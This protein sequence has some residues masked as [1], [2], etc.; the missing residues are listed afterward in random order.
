MDDHHFAIKTQGLQ[1]IFGDVVAV[2]GIDLDVQRG[3]ITGLLGGNGAGKSTT[4]AML[5]G[6]LEPTSGAIEILGHDLWRDRAK[7]APL[8]NF[9]SPYVDL[10]NRLTVRQNLTVYGHLY[11]VAHLH[12]R[13]VHLAERLQI[14]A[15][16]DRRHGTLSSG[17][18]TR[19]SLAKSLLNEPR[20]LLL[21]EPTASLDPDT[22]DWVRSLLID[23][24]QETG[25]TIFMAS[26][27]MVEVERMCDEVVM[28]GQGKIVDHGSPQK[29]LESYGRPNLEEVFLDIARNRTAAS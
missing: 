26:H 19:A 23:Y 11:G 17:Q 20:L 13:I 24:R 22:A 28:M 21:D 12:D 2:D 9:S 18:K 25:A 6:L 27:N 15:L 10:P 3:S 5:L 14:G 1:K 8:V 29:L 4:M 16:L 7:I